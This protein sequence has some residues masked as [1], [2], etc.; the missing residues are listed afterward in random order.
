MRGDLAPLLTPGEPSA[1]EGVTS[2]AVGLITRAG[3]SK[4]ITYNGWPL[5][6]F[7]GDEMAGDAKGQSSGD[8]WFMVSVFGGPKQNRAA[9][10]SKSNLARG[11]DIALW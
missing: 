8:V 5:Y 4:Q 2:G 9:V 7:A 6:H 10:K 11:L 1:G 3:G